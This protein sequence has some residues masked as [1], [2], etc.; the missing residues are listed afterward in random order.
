MVQGPK[1]ETRTRDLAVEDHRIWGLGAYGA[2]ETVFELLCWVKTTRVYWS[3]SAG[4]RD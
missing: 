2:V 4:Q 1:Q 3:G